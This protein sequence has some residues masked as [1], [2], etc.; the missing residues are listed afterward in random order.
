MIVFILITV[1]VVLYYIKFR[2]FRKHL[3]ELSDSLPGVGYLPILG[4]IHWV[5]GG[6]EKIYKNI[7]RLGELI[8]GTGGI[9][10]I[11][12]GPSLYVVISNP[13]DVQKLLETSLEKD[14]SYRFLRT[15][16][17]N[18]LFVAPLNLWK[19]QRR[20]L[21]PI[22]ANRVIEDYIEV[23]H[24]EAVTLVKQLDE[25][26]G[27][28][29]FDVFKHITSCTLDISFET[30]MG[31][32]M[33]L[34]HTADSAY[35]H[36][37]NCVMSIINMR[38]FKPW[39]QP[40]AIFKLTP[41]S[42]TQ[43]ENIYLTRKFTEE[44]IAKRRIMHQNGIYKEGRKDLLELLLREDETKFNNKELREHLDAIT[45]AGNDTTALTIS[46]T[47]LLLGMH[48]R[49]QELVYKELH[50]IFGDSKRTT[51]KEDLYKM[52]Y[53]E[54]VIKETMRL[55]TVTPIIARETKSEVKLYLR[56]YGDPT[57][58]ALIQIDSCLKTVLIDILVLTYPLATDL[59]IA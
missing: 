54:R 9:S 30:A 21:V 31:E 48:Q 24:N 8:E 52:E 33:D 4:H 5:I 28:P 45:I 13:E 38:I 34:Q 19:R 25:N 53:L 50:E 12:I 56:N 29:E 22:F 46:Y 6:P 41:Y 49:E 55:Y 18:G 35:L 16:L 20:A 15:W 2:Y 1:C 57:L 3:Y 36:A 17:G 14:S 44:V 39:M 32:K 11:W 42:K 26:L 51:T 47:L 10:K 7:Q 27:K 23:F 43:E 37:R 40:D 59:E 58:K